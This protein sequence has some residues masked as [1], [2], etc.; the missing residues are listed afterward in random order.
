[1]KGISELSFDTKMSKS[2]QHL[3]KLNH[4]PVVVGLILFIYLTLLGLPIYFLVYL[5]KG[6][7]RTF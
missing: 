1:M 6:M 3:D 5:Y 2:L 4:T 7:W